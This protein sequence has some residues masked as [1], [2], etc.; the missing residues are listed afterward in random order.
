METLSTKIKIAAISTGISEVIFEGAINCEQPLPTLKSANEA[1]ILFHASFPQSE[2]AKY[3]LLNWITLT[4]NLE[5]AIGA[6]RATLNYSR[7]E[8]FALKQ[9]LKFF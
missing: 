2:E 7:Y 9:I 6:Y 5:D 8:K 3:F 1:K 4:V